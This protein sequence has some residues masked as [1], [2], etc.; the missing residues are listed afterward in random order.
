MGNA[1]AAGWMAAGEA[2]RWPGFAQAG[3]KDPE[4]FVLGE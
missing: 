1:P 3:S 4:N 2:R